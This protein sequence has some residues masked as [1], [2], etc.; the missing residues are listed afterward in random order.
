[1]G[2]IPSVSRSQDFSPS[3]DPSVFALG[4][5]LPP[6]SSGEVISSPPLAGGYNRCQSV[7]LGRC[8]QGLDSS[9][10][11]VSPGSPSSDKHLGTEG[12]SSLSS[13]MG[14]PASDPPCPRPVGQRHGCSLHQSA[15]QHSQLGSHGQGDK[16]SPLG[17]KQ[18]SGHFSD[19]HSGCAQLGSGLPQPF[20]SRPRRVVSTSG[21][22]RAD[23]RPLGH[24]RRG[25]LCF[26]AQ[27]ED[28]SICVK[29]PGPPGSSRGCPSDSLGG[30][31][32]A[33]SV[34]S[35]SA[36][37]QGSDEAQSGGCSHHTGSSRLAPKDV[38]RRR[39]QAPGRRSIAPS[40]SSG[41]A[42]SGSSLP[43]QFTVAAFGGVV[44]ETAVLR[45]CGFSSQVIRTMLRARKPSLPKIYHR[46]WRSYFRWCEAQ[47]LSPVTFFVPHLF[48]FL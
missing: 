5:P 40:T 22:L 33:L 25:P 17:G 16:D 2:Q 34:P 23:L 39:G 28:S 36:P 21:G 1:M 46:T 20:L 41:P 32:P 7:V 27:S 44:V 12:D 26:S 9:R 18:G 37:S 45:A 8:V 4:A 30:V 42:V 11:L 47:V 29:V 31:C 3:S 14:V 10:P 13:S 43:P 48:S 35:P 24:S 6:S 19:S 15:R 38:V